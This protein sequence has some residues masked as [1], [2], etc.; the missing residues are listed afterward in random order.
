MTKQVILEAQEYLTIEKDDGY[1]RIIDI[2]ALIKR[3]GPNEVVRFLKDYLRDKEKGLKSLILIDK[4]QSRIDQYVA[5]MFRMHM[6]IKTLEEGKEVKSI[7]WPK[8]R[9]KES[10]QLHTRNRGNHSR[11]RFGENRS[12]DAPDRFPCEQAQRVA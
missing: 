10:G 2:Y 5:T 3:H 7:A 9:A 12:N 8:Q 1:K 4:T 11:A 6:A